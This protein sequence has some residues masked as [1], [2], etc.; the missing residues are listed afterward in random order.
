MA[1]STYPKS[2]L[3]QVEQMLRLRSTPLSVTKT[4]DLRNISYEFEEC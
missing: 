2:L 3:T 1:E 4:P